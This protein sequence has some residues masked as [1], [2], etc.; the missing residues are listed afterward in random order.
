VRPEARVDW[1]WHFVAVLGGALVDLTW[2]DAIASLALCTILVV[3]VVYLADG[4]WLISSTWATAAAILIIGLG[5]RVISVRG[6]ARVGTHERFHQV[7]RVAAAV[8]GVVALLAGL[9]A[10]VADSAYSLKILVMSSIIV[11]GAGLVSHV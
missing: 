2:R 11:W 1:Q 5:G 7:L 3:Y 4:L 6:D 10:I 8:F 9:A